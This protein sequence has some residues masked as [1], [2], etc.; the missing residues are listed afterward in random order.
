MGVSAPA[1][2]LAPRHLL[3]AREDGLFAQPLDT[4]RFE[5]AGDAV[6]VAGQVNTRTGVGGTD[7]VALSVSE[8]GDIVYRGPRRL[9][10]A[11]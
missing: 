4:A 1:V 7:F 2:F 10:E 8:A 5:L 6:R 3:L 9:L 11:S